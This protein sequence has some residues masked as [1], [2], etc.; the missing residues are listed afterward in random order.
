MDVG[1]MQVLVTREIPGPALRR[2]EAAA[3][4]TVW[5]RELPP[6][7]DTLKEM[8]QPMH[9]LLC[10]LTERVDGAALQVAPEL[11]VVSTM[12]VGVDHIDLAAC[13][14]RN[15]AV[16]HTPGVLTDATADFTLGLML[17]LGRRIMEGKRFAERGEWRTWSPTL[18]L[19]KDLNACNIG[20]LGLGRIGGAVARRLSPF[21]AR[22][23]FYDH[24]R[25][26]G[27]DLGVEIQYRPFRELV[28]SADILSIHL[29]LTRNTDGLIGKEELMLMPS[30]S[31][32]VNTARGAIVDTEALVTAL[33][34]GWLGGAALDVTHPEPLPPDHP[35]YDL[36]NCLIT[37]HIASAG[38]TTRER[39]ADMA[40]DNVL[41]GLRDEPLP[42]PAV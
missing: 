35:L 9:G 20:I 25:N 30:D 33:R 17:A 4:V 11:K 13:R 3:Q 18:L 32:L 36:R 21:G 24:D 31:L 37:P 12:S 40:V 41:A 8:L 22:L 39:M 7:A 27:P 19:G 42:H 23:M 2:L 1:A 28:R 10:L 38:R 5:E 14:E 26:A 15:I 29:P 34:E 16:G 6:D